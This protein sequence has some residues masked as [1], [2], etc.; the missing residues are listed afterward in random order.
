MISPK[1]LFFENIAYKKL[2]KSLDGIQN[3]ALLVPK[4]N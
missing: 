1:N 3:T 4:V 2:W